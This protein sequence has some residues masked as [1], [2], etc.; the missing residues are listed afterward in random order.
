MGERRAAGGSS[1]TPIIFTNTSTRQC[2]MHAYPGVAAIDANGR[3]LAQA[4]RTL[5]GMLSGFFAG[6]TPPDVTLDPGQAAS[7][8]VDGIDVPLGDATDCPQPAGFL[9]TPPNSRTSVDVRGDVPT[10]CADLK[11]HPVVTGTDGG[12]P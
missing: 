9:V 12:K 11:V 5:A 4:T 1:A 6:S 10:L 7:A 3:Q 2:F 8:G